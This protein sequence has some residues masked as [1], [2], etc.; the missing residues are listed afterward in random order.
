MY[1]WLVWDLTATI[2]YAR[3]CKPHAYSWPIWAGIESGLAMW[4]VF[5]ERKVYAN[6]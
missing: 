4:E 3:G 2:Y 1:I 6:K 5:K